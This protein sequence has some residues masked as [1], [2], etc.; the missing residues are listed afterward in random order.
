MEFT[1]K[2][3]LIY[4]DDDGN[5][6]SRDIPGDLT[7]ILVRNEIFVSIINFMLI[8]SVSRKIS[9]DI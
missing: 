1:D 4:K 7:T 6:V 5:L 9:M 3:S 2:D 8:Y